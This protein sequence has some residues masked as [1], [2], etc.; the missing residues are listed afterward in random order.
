METLIL[1]SHSKRDLNIIKEIALKFG[2]TVEE[3]T[4]NSSK[5]IPNKTTIK[6]MK[7]TDKGKNLT[8][9]LSHQDLMDK[10]LS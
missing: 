7:E 9:S 2:I 1:N 6:V 8:Q 10:L 4:S 3:K 5:N